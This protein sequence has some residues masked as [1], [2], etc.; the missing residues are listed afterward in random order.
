[1]SANGRNGFEPVVPE[2]VSFDALYGLEVMEHDPLAGIIAGRVPVRDGLKQASGALHGGVLVAAAETLATRATFMAV[3]DAGKTAVG[4]SND[5]AYM[6]PVL[7]G[8]AHVTA[9]VT[10]RGVDC[11]MWDVE[12]RDDADRLCA[13]S[14][15]LVA[16]RPL[17]RT[18]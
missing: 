12:T 17:G 10:D 18:S 4:M 11:W 14:R 9:R 15:V 13:Q 8:Y 2:D 6:Q 3:F 5:T 7:D 1:M 16:V